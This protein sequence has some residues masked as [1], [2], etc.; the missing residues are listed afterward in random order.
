MTTYPTRLDDGLVVIGLPVGIDSGDG[1]P[2][3]MVR[4]GETGTSSAVAVAEAGAR[5]GAVA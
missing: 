5:N 3:V 1:S 2:A 4:A